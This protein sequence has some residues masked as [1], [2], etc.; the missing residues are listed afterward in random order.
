MRQNAEIGLFARPSR[1]G[2]MAIYGGEKD[3]PEILHDHSFLG[4]QLFFP[5][6]FLW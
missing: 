2:K 4:N 6:G 1:M 5:G 3:A